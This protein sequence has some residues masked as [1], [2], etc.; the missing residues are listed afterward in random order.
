MCLVGQ[1]LL[2]HADLTLTRLWNN[3]VSPAQR[4][5]IHP[6]NNNNN[7]PQQMSN[8]TLAMQQQ[9]Q[10]GGGLVSLSVMPT[11]TGGGQLSEDKLKRLEGR[12]QMMPDVPVVDSFAKVHFAFFKH[13]CWREELSTFDRGDIS[14]RVLQR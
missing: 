12:I 1:P 4:T 13:C 2:S 10:L 9:Q 11:L 7:Q 5:N 6:M 3:H 14:S 8:P